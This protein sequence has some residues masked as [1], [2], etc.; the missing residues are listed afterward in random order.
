MASRGVKIAG[1]GKYLPEKVMTNTDLEKI[2]D[3]SD[4]WI[5]TRSGI[6]ARRIVA[7]GEATSDLAARAAEAALKS[8]GVTAEEI[9]LII[10]GTF[11]PDFMFPSTACIVQDK[12]GA[13]NAG[14]FDLQAACSG[15]VY[16]LSVGAQFI[17]SG[18]MKNV[19]VIG[20][21]AVSRIL[22]W[23][24]RSTCVLFGDGAGAAVLQPS[25]ENSLL[26]FCLGS[27][28]SGG[29]HLDM[30]AGGS[31]L[32]ASHATVDSRQ[33]F[34]KMNGKEI[35]KFAVK[36]IGEASEKA[37]DK[38][39]L[40]FADV[41]IFIPHQANIRIIKSAAQKFGISMDKVVVNLDKYG[42]T[43]AATVPIALEEAVKEGRI[44]KGSV[45]LMVGFGA[46]LTWGSAV[47]RW[48]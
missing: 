42:N 29:C 37:L 38:A 20:A 18:T 35:F 24:D 46:G 8:A 5:K 28:G 3:T 4:E 23:E 11:S 22:D 13:K 47:L 14:A 44:Q 15:F 41:D 16:A 39:G 2:I 6:G 27:D 7:E 36:I 30:P 9:E 19:L 10:V 45:V 26:S 31:K 43:S 32:P 34:L 33:H 40:T 25:E 48:V 17:S 1:I 21:E 12:I